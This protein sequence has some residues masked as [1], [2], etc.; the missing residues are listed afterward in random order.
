M[1]LQ[2]EER[3]LAI[4]YAGKSRA[5]F[6]YLWTVYNK[7]FVIILS[8]VCEGQISFFCMDSFVIKPP[9]FWYC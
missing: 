5:N 2:I 9:V 4:N 8:V 1:D 7:K 3:D 6:S